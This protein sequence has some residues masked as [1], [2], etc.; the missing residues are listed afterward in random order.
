MYYPIHV[1]NV[2]ALFLLSLSLV[3]CYTPTRLTLLVYTCTW[4]AEHSEA[5][6]LSGFEVADVSW[7]WLGGGE[8]RGREGG[9]SG[10]GEG[11]GP[12]L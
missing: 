5:K 2:Q 8:V 9:T 7:T 3:R 11:K 1:P 4:V 12:I 10:E 6:T